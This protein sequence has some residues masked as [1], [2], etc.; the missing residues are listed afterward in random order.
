MYRR[1]KNLLGVSLIIFAILL[2]QIPMPE[3]RADGDDIDTEQISQD[4]EAAQQ[5]ADV[6]TPTAN[7]TKTVTVTYHF[8][9]PLSYFKNLPSGTTE[10]DGIAVLEVTQEIN[11]ETGD[12][13]DK[14]PINDYLPNSTHELTIGSETRSA[15]LLNWHTDKDYTWNFDDIITSDITLYATWDM[16]DSQY[17]ITYMATGADKYSSQTKTVKAGA[18]IPKPD[19]TP[20]KKG[21]HF[22]NWYLDTSAQTLVDWN[23]KVAKDMT[24]YAGWSENEFT[25]TFD[26][27][28]GTYADTDTGVIEEAASK[29]QK[30]S[31]VTALID[32]DKI[33]YS[34]EYQT[35]DTWYQDQE[36]F[37][38]YDMDITING[39][40]TLY[41]KWYKTDAKGFV[42]SP[43]GKY[44][45]QY[46]GNLNSTSKVEVKIPD[47]VTKIGPNAFS[48]MS[49]IRSVTLP[50]AI[51]SIAGDAF[52]GMDTV[53]D[54]VYLLA[55]D[56]KDT[57]LSYQ[58]AQELAKQYSKFNYVTYLKP[59]SVIFNI[60]SSSF[61]SNTASGI[62]NV[63]SYVD[64][65]ASGLESDNYYVTVS[66]NANTNELKNYFAEID[67]Q[68]VY[69]LEISMTKGISG[70][71]D[72]KD[73]MNYTITF[74]LPDQWQNWD[75]T[76]NNIKVYSKNY[77]TKELE[78]LTVDKVI[79]EN[80]TDVKCVRFKTWHFSPFV[81][82]FNGT[83]PNNN[84]GNNNNDGN[85]SNNSGN[86]GNSDNSGSSDNGGSSGGG[87]STNGGSAAENGTT[88]GT[89]T[90]TP[91]ITQISTQPA[92]NG[93][94][95]PG[96]TSQTGT[97]H[98]KD[99][100]PKT[101]DPLEYRT[102]MVC[103]LF[104]M[105]VLMI[106]IGNKKKTSAFSRYRRG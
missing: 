29:G 76:V 47:T 50:S 15:T 2:S 65:A 73:T 80:D 71:P 60:D 93:A 48:D 4:T 20:I 78:E 83:I 77:V 62:S 14:T 10:V 105:G 21:Y 68:K 81:L 102:L 106:L 40:L 32:P 44:L 66:P 17:T 37:T 33:S 43:D 53:A 74:P 34:T 11:E 72:Y 101:G 91:D 79:E 88:G 41:K 30:L 89:G 1:L 58:K 56:T 57:S 35:D 97:G 24:L 25:I 45:Y 59:E 51:S 84:N 98:V 5:D 96:G 28:G 70:T 16:G 52:C 19:Y 12:V 49:N 38:V 85:N 39:D 31:D 95:Q 27:N 103:G 86:N 64:I 94:A 8:G 6:A 42:L 22:T 69:Y 63:S 75:V 7:T 90:S 36:C 100:T 61:A 82:T 55:A 99:S 3:V 26:L 104:S 13:I 18:T 92:G 67:Q 87:T 46:T 54:E 9:F 23:Q